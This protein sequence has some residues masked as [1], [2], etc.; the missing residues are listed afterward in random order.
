MEKYYNAP[1][2]EII[3]L[4][5]KGLCSGDVLTGSGLDGNNSQGNKMNGAP[6]RIF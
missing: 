3:K 1:V 5:T 6:K 4:E 2:I